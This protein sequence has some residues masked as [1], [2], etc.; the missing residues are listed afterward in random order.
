MLKNAD[1]SVINTV[2]NERTVQWYSG[3]SLVGKSAKAVTEKGLE[4]ADY[5]TI[6]IPLSSLRSPLGDIEICPLK[7]QKTY[8]VIGKVYENALE[9]FT[10]FLKQNKVYTVVSVQDN[11]YGPQKV[12]HIRIDCK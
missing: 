4:N 5:I 7:P 9:K 1:I 11:R 3:V 8:I 10:E 2:G 12:Q 6:R